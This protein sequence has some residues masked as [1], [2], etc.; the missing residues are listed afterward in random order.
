MKLFQGF[1]AT[2]NVTSSFGLLK[3]LLLRIVYSVAILSSR[4]KLY[5]NIYII[6]IYKYL[7]MNIYIL[8][9]NYSEET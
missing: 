3:L 9:K 2:V 1:K 4:Y 8:Y 7:Y 5:I 6:Y